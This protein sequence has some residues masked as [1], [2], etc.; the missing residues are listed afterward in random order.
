MNN[1]CR[2]LIF[3]AAFF[4]SASAIAEKP[5]KQLKRQQKSNVAKSLLAL[6]EPV[7]LDDTQ[8]EKI[9]AMGEELDAQTKTLKEDASLTSELLKKRRAAMK[10]M[11]D[12]ELKGKERMAAVNEAAGLT[13]DQ[14]KA[15]NQSMAKERQFRTSAIALLSDEQKTKLPEQLTKFLNKPGKGKGKQKKNKTA[16]E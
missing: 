10:S 9:T 4:S 14:A 8:T 13:E 5:G 6:L 7:G 1:L 12:S 15:F 3:T 2:A 11:K 16:S